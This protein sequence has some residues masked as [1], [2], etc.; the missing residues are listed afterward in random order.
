MT[1]PELMR[2]TSRTARTLFLDFD[3][4]LHPN[5]AA[6]QQRFARLPLL[7]EAIGDH[8]VDIVISSSWRFEWSIQRLRGFFPV[9]L[10]SNI[11]NTTG[12][13]FIGRHARWN[14]ITAYCAAAGISNWRALDDARF[15]FPDPCSELIACEGGRGIEKAQQERIRHWLEGA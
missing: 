2:D 1:Q 4:V 11:V 8:P 12:S 14:E 13:A 6:P 7:V 5:L 15:E 10:R 9:A 3:G